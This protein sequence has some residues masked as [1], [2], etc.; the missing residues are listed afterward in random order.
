MS[1]TNFI[2]MIMYDIPVTE[3]N[4]Q[5]A[6]RKLSRYLQMEG[7]YCFQ[8]SIYIKPLSEKHKAQTHI[9]AIKDIAL[10]SSH[11]RALMLTYSAFLAMEVITG[12]DTWGEQLIKNPNSII[13]L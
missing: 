12:A 6:Y 8:G 13:T 9:E 11:I 10:E 4:Y 5:K 3:A 7:F 1:Q 2:L